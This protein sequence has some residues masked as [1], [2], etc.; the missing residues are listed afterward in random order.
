[1]EGVECGAAALGIV[2]G[3]FGR[4]VPLT[5]L[6]EETG[7]SRDG[8]SALNIIKVAEKYGLESHGYKMEV[9]DLY[10]L[11]LPVIVFW[12]FGH[13]LVVEGFDKKNVYL[14][15]PAM[16]PRT[17]SYEDFSKDYTG[18]VLTFKPTASFQKGGKKPSLYDGLKERVADSRTALIFIVLV[19]LALVIPGL[20][21]PIFTKIFIDDYLVNQF[22]DWIQPLL[23]GMGITAII[24]GILTYIQ[25]KHLL[26][27][28]TKI[29]LTT[30]SKF[31]WHVF[32]LPMEFFTQRSTGDISSRIQLND[33]IAN[34]LS[35]QL[36]TSILSCVTIVFYVIVMFFYDVKLTFVGIIIA[37]L[38]IFA[39]QYISR[40]RKDLNKRMIREQYLLI[41]TSMQGIG[42]I[43]TLKATGAESDFFSKW[44]SYLAKLI[45]AQQR[46]GVYTQVLTAIPPFL[47]ALNTAIILWLGSMQVMDGNMTMGMLVAFQ[48]LMASFI[49]PV[50]NLVNLGSNLQLIEGDIE[51]V[52]DV[53]ENEIDKQSFPD[54]DADRIKVL[55]TT[56]K[57]KLDGYLEMKDVTFGYNPLSAPLLTDF[58]LSLKPGSRV[59]LV[60]ASGSGKSTIARLVSGLYHP[61]SGDITFDTLKRN[62]IPREVMVNSF[63]MV[64]QEIFMFSGTIRDNLTMWNETIKQDTIVKAAK[65]ADIHDIIT[66]RPNGYD[67]VIAENGNNFSGGQKQRLEIARALCVNPTLLVM[68]EATSSLDPTTEKFIDDNVRRRGC[69]CLII[70]HRLSTIRDSDEIIVLDDGKVVQRGTHEELIKEGGMYANLIKM[71]Q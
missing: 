6:R 53:T 18:V 49:T 32:K 8:A 54:E 4:Y 14:N 43:E 58:N 33:G 47:T 35:G 62:E 23:I 64:N 2:L 61:W 15:D 29:A 27:L 5:K 52:D 39:L 30:S 40:K 45:N 24:R 28:E 41:G 65:D 60:G 13:F 11:D 57:V 71:A 1:M 34:L 55:Q 36:A 48:S 67:A 26:K 56:P 7:V 31:F 46:L 50:N 20:V 44:S 38:N 51:K 19:G 42:A 3:Y 21:V 37:G 70:A 63:S 68:D 69:T 66:S 59:A 25:Q 9:E 16:G 12:G 10:K 17:V 22:K